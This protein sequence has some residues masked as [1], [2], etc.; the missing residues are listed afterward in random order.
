MAALSGRSDPRSS[1]ADSAPTMHRKEGQLHGC[2]TERV[3]G[4]QAQPRSLE[5]TFPSDENS[6]L[7]SSTETQRK[8]GK[9]DAV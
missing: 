3:R 6:E 9:G 2:S 1:A 7:K 8:D 5:G 4:E